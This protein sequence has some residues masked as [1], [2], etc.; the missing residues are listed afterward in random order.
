MPPELT[1]QQQFNA[2][3]DEI[4]RELGTHCRTAPDTKNAHR[5]AWL[6]IDNDGRALS[7]R[8]H[9][10]DQPARLQVYAALP[11]GADLPTPSIG[12]T[13][14]SAWHI[15]REITRRLYPL[16]AEAAEVAAV[17]I[18]QKEAEARARRAV[19]EAVAGPLPGARIQEFHRRTQVSWQCTPEPQGQPGPVQTDRVQAVIGPSGEW[20]SVEASGDLQAIVA[21]LTALAA[22]QQY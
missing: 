10:S 9:D 20:I 11:D 6:I 13:A 15:A 12:V 3:A 18:E 7:L 17:L 5:L 16:H 2:F 19:A 14:S 4:A 1:T 22:A 21:M 8:Q